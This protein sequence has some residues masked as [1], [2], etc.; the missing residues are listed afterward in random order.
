[1]SRRKIGQRVGAILSAGDGV[2]KL[3]G[4]GIY[5]GD[6]VPPSSGGWMAEALAEHGLKNPRLDLDSGET[7]WGCQCWWG[8]EDEVKAKVERWLEQGMSLREATMAEALREEK[9][10]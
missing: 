10:R 6:E 7:V 2:V 4:Y 1:M 3:L 5:V 9:G 8:P